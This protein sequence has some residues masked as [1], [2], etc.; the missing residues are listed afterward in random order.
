MNQ[1]RDL[2]DAMFLVLTWIRKHLKLFAREA[3]KSTKTEFDLDDGL[4]M[5]TKNTNLSPTPIPVMAIRA[6]QSSPTMER[7]I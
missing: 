7:S 2:I 4:N 1:R 3:A 5:L 6:S